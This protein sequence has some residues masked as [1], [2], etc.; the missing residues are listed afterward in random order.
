MILVGVEGRRG[1]HRMKHREHGMKH[2]EHKEKQRSIF[3][4]VREKSKESRE[5]VHA[6]EDSHVSQSTVPLYTSQSTVSL[7]PDQNKP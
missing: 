3:L 4:K 5:D 7:P 2:R 6:R 1:R